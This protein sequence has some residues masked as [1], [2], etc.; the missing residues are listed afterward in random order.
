MSTTMTIRL[1]EE[2]KDQL[3][4][5]SEATKR[6]KSFLAAEAIREY[7]ETNEWQIQEIKSAL[8]EA[9]AGDFASAAEVKRVTEKWN[10]R[11]R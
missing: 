4:R 9:D 8:A 2:T 10:G 6:S 3:D 1:D 5:L 7:I 11:V